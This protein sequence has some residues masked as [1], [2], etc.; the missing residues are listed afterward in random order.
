MPST[1]PYFTIDIPGVQDVVTIPAL[2]NS[3]RRRDRAKLAATKRSPIPEPIRWVPGLI[4]WLDDGQDIL[5]VGLETLKFVSRRIAPRF[6]PFIGWALTISDVLN[7]ATAGLSFLTT[8]QTGKHSWEAA[9]L[10]LFP[11]RMARIR[12]AST[13][14]SSSVHW[15]PY[16]L[17]GGQVLKTFTGYGLTL[18]GIMGMIS[19]ATWGAY[20]AAQGDPIILRGP[21]SSDIAMRTGAWLADL[22]RYGPYLNGLGQD[23]VALVGAS[24]NVALQMLADYGTSTDPGRLD[25]AFGMPIFQR[26]TWNPATRAA[27][28][29]EGF[30]PDLLQ[31]DPSIATAADQLYSNAYIN[32]SDRWH[33]FLT[34]VAPE[35][36]ASVTANAIHNFYGEATDR[37]MAIAGQAPS[38]VEP[39]LLSVERFLLVVIELGILPLWLCRGTDQLWFYQPATGPLHGPL[40]TAI[41]DQPP[42]PWGNLSPPFAPLPSKSA[43]EQLRLWWQRSALLHSGK[44]THYDMYGW[45]QRPFERAT[46]IR[47]EPGN[48]ELRGETPYDQ[49]DIPAVMTIG[50]H[51][52]LW[53]IFDLYGNAGIRNN[54]GIEDG[55][56]PYTFDIGVLDKLKKDPNRFEE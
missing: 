54:M 23:D 55:A 34:D 4:N 40:S 12:R 6:L 7:L 19:D 42:G 29:A 3:Q 30:D 9:M 37:A 25:A 5:A 47:I 28:I 16:L 31:Y 27:L 26:E 48:V 32:F 10:R 20:R 49:A 21:A 35:M 13:F 44:R 45:G 14:L 18:G 56:Y 43:P 41:R 52:P 17:Q 39:L 24:A 11:G 22:P 2:E 33:N 15:A 53:A 1:Q 50:H 38:D 36:P 46:R 51:A 8:G